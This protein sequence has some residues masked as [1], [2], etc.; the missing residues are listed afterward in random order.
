[1]LIHLLTPR[2]LP[3]TR[4]GVPKTE[5]EHDVLKRNKKSAR[6][7]A[8]CRNI[9]PVFEEFLW[10]CRSLKFSE[11]PDYDR[12][13][14][15]FRD[16]M[17]DSGFPDSDDFIWPPPVVAS[18]SAVL[19]LPHIHSP[20]K[21]KAVVQ[22]PTRQILAAQ[23]FEEILR[24]LD[25]LAIAPQPAALMDN[26]PA[27]AEL[28]KRAAEYARTDDSARPLQPP[29]RP[30]LKVVEI[31]SESEDELEDDDDALPPVGRYPK[32]HHL[33]I[34]ITRVLHT[35]EH[36]QLGVLVEH[37]ANVL[38]GSNSSR[39]LTKEG[40]AFLDVLHQQLSDPAVPVVPMR[41]S[42]SRSDNSSLPSEGKQLAHVKLGVVARLRREVGVADG[43][44]ALAKMIEEFGSV[45]NRSTG[46]T[47]TKD[48]FA[49][50]E[51]LA[52]R[53]KSLR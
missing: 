38:R 43:T 41:T 52:A 34:L 14:D 37:F 51:G 42:R 13:I 19:R 15:E 39:S 29:K 30:E 33:G 32:A 18:P 4:H 3:W 16:F 36:K 11:R 50:L 26:N 21:A 27:R 7:E 12:W 17:V 40:F 53:L 9:P 20:A 35:K 2:G 47:I 10:Y 22:P 8:L 25:K 24:G 6:P 5:E 49:F 23:E 31:S 28:N 44:H 48:G 45:T 46:R 1:M